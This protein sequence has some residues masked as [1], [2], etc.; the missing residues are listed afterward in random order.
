MMSV[1]SLPSAVEKLGVDVEEEDHLVVGQL[2][3]DL[4]GRRVDLA[5]AVVVVRSAGENGQHQHLGLR[6]LGCAASATIA[7]TP[8]AISAGVSPPTLLVPIISTA[9]LGEMPSMLPWSQPPEHVLRLIAADAQVH[10]I[11]LGV[12]LLPHAAAAGVSQPWVIESPMKSRSTLPCFIR[13]LSSLSRAI[14]PGASRLLGGGH[15][16]GSIS[17]ATVG[18]MASAQTGGPWHSDG[19]GRA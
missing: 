18:S 9:S 6:Q 14:Q 19:S 1:E 13:S 7:L 2:G 4:V 11:A 15:V 12:I 3:D 17:L 16:R 8:A 5:Q 10:G